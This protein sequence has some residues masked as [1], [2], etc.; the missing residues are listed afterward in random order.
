MQVLFVL[1]WAIPVDAAM[2]V[3]PR[4]P[5]VRTALPRLSLTPKLTV[6]LNV[7]P[8]LGL[9]L[10]PQL[11]PVLTPAE[12]LPSLPVAMAL[13]KTILAQQTD[14]PGAAQAVKPSA[15]ASAKAAA[16]QG[17][18]GAPKAAA[19]FDG[20]AHNDSPPPVLGSAEGS[21]YY[22]GPGLKAVFRMAKL[23]GIDNHDVRVLLGRPSL[24]EFQAWQ[25][26]PAAARLDE[27][28]LTR[29]SYLLGVYK[30]LATIFNDKD[31]QQRWLHAAN[32]AFDGQPAIAVMMEDLEGLIRVRKYL[33]YW[34]YNGW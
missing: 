19:V 17:K 4:A 28:T 7:S 24:E 5:S 14:K 1:L 12:A 10:A 23:W 30:G 21:A 29:V 9:T 6:D 18:K 26:D 11:A 16:P 31:N 27:E 33:D 2:R 32:K 13:Q 25:A 22:S 8:A 15:F 3:A 34:A 20:L